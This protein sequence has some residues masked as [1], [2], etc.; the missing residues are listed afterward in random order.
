MTNGRN[1][2]P[3][4]PSPRIDRAIQYISFPEWT[5]DRFRKEFPGQYEKGANIAPKK[6]IHFK[7]EVRGIVAKAYVN[8]EAEPSITINDLKMGADAKGAVGLWVDDGSNG[9]FSNL[10]ITSE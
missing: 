10:R 2:E 1:A 8:N 9:Y 5:F 3:I 6:W 4:P 7:I